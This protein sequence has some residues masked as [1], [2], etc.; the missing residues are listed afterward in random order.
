MQVANPIYDVVFKY[1]LD[2]EKVAKLILSAITG[3]EIK[4]LDFN[5]T[6]HRSEIEKDITV[7]HLDFAAK[8]IDENDEEKIIIIEIQKAKLPSD[9]MRFRRY[10]GEQY[11][12]KKNIKKTESSS[13]LKALPILSIY[14]LGHKLANTKSP[15]I[16]VQRD[17]IDLITGS[18]LN[19]KEE[20]IESLTHDSFIIQIPY[21]KKHK[22]NNLETILS[23]FNQDN[24]SE[25]NHLI[26]I[27]ESDYHTKYQ[28]IIRRLLKAISEPELRKNMDI[29]D[30]ILQDFQIMRRMLEKGKEEIEKSHKEIKKKKKELDISKKKLQENKKELQENKKELQENKKE[31]QENKK[32]L[33]ENKKELQENKKEL[34]KSKK[35]LQE[36]KKE[37]E[38]NKKKLEENKKT[39][40]IK[41]QSIV[42]SVNEMHRLGL[43]THKI[44]KLTMLSIKKIE[45]I[46]EK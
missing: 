12:S 26:N 38:E 4:K 40:I 43:S 28:P 10:L 31:L 9:I 15:I 16:K 22:R 17:Y 14:F 27:K 18:K 33:Q 3:F 5:P 19:K 25:N 13:K 7:L 37:I 45:E 24:L 6:E 11:M 23:I 8:I 42:N 32:E 46:L 29:E 39:L 30:E 41:E 35:E 36:N 21:L 20:F 34:H 44:S 2:D 1:L